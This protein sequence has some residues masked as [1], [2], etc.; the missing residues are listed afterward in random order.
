MA[1]VD[2]LAL[3]VAGVRLQYLLQHGKAALL[4]ENAAQFEEHP[5]WLLP[6]PSWGW[7]SPHDTTAEKAR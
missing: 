6:E 2:N 4:Y 3:I 5:H 7:P 1:V